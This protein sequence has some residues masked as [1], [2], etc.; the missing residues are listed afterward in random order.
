MSNAT[1]FQ[2][3]IPDA[4]RKVTEAMAVVTYVVPCLG[5]DAACGL[6]YLLRWLDS[7]FESFEADGSTELEELSANACAVAAVLSQLNESFDHQMLHAAHT[8]LGVA[9]SLLDEAI[10]KGGAQ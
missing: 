10:E 8:V 4:R 6:L 7:R 9:K 2:S 3:V 5:S 1:Y